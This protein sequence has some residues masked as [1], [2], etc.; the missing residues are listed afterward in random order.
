M[1]KK[2]SNEEEVMWQITRMYCDMLEI[3]LVHLQ[4]SRELVTTVNLPIS[5]VV[6][7]R[8]H[9]DQIEVPRQLV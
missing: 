4:G 6:S 1:R 9:F 3:H 5:K 8:Y 7:G 2:G